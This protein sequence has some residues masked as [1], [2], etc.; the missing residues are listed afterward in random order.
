M[1]FQVIQTESMNLSSC[2]QM[3]TR[4]AKNHPLLS[5]EITAKFALELLE[6]WN[7]FLI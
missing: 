4:L 5:T 3:R 2:E 7:K 6:I 1:K